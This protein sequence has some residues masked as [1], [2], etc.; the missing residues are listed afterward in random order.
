M[1]Q[2]A[3]LKRALIKEE[4]VALTGDF[5]EALVL[6]QFLFW[7]S[8]VRDYDKLLQEELELARRGGSEPELPL[9][10]GWIYKKSEELSEELMVGKSVTTIR[11][12]IS[13]LLEKGWLN[14]RNN[15]VHAWDKTKQYRVNLAKVQKD[16]AALGYPLDGYALPDSPRV[17]Q[18]EVS[19]LQIANP[20]SQN[21]LPNSQNT[22]AIPEKTSKTTTENRSNNTHYPH[23]FEAFWT[24]YPKQVNKWGAFRE[25]QRAL[26][27]K[28]P[29]PVSPEELVTA[30]SNYAQ[31]KL[32][33]ETRY[34]MKPAIFLG[35]DCH[36]LD[37][38]Q[39]PDSGDSCHQ[40]L[41]AVSVD[42]ATRRSLTEQTPEELVAI[43]NRVPNDSIG[44]TLWYVR[45]ELQSRGFDVDC[46]GGRFVLVQDK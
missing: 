36:Y 37:Y 40:G 12:I 10:H 32:G 5:M 31:A 3:I 25:W 33:V 7:T 16:L 24:A 23:D 21:S 8:R 46:V 29:Q 27:R 41:P 39:V 43:L 2:P 4:L 18:D 19:N 26:K 35:S 45:P 14:E 13:R 34:L 1:T 28:K 15:P 22:I 17:A 11:R 9:K 20:I 6:N 44:R 38:V 30:A 42:A